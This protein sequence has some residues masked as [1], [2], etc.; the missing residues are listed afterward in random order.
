MATMAINQYILHLSFQAQF[1]MVLTLGFIAGLFMSKFYQSLEW[2]FFFALG[3]LSVN[4]TPSLLELINGGPLTSL[5]HHVFQSGHY[6]GFLL[7]SWMIA[8]PIGYI[9]QKVLMSDYYRRTLF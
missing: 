7:T 5:I 2:A 1:L 3:I 6:V 8:I 4:M 9:T